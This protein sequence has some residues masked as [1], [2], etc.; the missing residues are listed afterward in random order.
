LPLGSA[1]YRMTGLTADMAAARQR[2][3]AHKR[4]EVGWTKGRG[5]VA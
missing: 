1:A 4:A 2:V 3:R 5:S